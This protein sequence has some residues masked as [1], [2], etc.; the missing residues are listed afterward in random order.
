MSD[1]HTH[2]VELDPR[3]YDA[4][5]DVD[6]PEG[7]DITVTIEVSTSTTSGAGD[8]PAVADGVAAGGEAALWE[9][10]RERGYTTEAE[11]P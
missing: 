11:E 2:T 3:K 9:V 8:I 10:L 1:R 4:P 5:E 6:Y 7:I